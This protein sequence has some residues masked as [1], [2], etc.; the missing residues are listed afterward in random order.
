MSERRS[1]LRQRCGPA[2]CQGAWVNDDDD[3]DDDTFRVNPT[4]THICKDLP[5]HPHPQTHKSHTQC[6]PFVAVR[7]ELG[8]PG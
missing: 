6:V 2:E 3:D 7:L 8:R 4:Y 1:M 5:L